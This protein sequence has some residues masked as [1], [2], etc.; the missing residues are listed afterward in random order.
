MLALRKTRAEF[1]LEFQDIPDPPPPGPAEV[2]VRV[3]A[4]GICG[5]DV[6]AYEWTEGYGFMVPHLPL[7]MGHEFAGT[8]TRNGTGSGFAEGN[9]VAVIPFVFCGHCANC[10]AGDT[11]NCLKREGIGLTRDGGFQREVRVPSRCCVAL[12]AALDAELA[13]LAEP[14][15]VGMEAVLTGEVGLG[16]TVLVLGPGTIGQAIALAAR[17][18]GAARVIVAGRADAPRFEVLRALGFS[19][20][21][22]VAEGP[23]Q[24]QV[25]ALT[26]GRAVDVVLEATGV[27][28]SITEGLAVLKKGGTIVAAG[29]HAAPLTLP[30]T[31]FVRMRH[32][33]RASHGAER[34]TWD[35]VLAH[36]G[37]DPEGF[38]PM[39]THRLP[40]E[41]G[42]EGFELARQ[43]A[44]SKVIL[45]P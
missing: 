12:P 4:V 30:L 41:R 23:L 44:A 26:G 15:G 18:A 40:L 19:D 38:R 43:R 42:L 32:Q 13:A 17:L 35:R 33:L 39:I 9:R 6:H 5:S 45:A 37:R 29:I 31:D 24:D 25:L 8:I 7:T 3:E 28:A 36:L 27:P 1:G 14:L 20:L 16:D 21:V 34:R 10:R 22:D 11:R 2:V